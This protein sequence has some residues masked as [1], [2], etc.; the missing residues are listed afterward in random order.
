MF[1]R[2]DEV[3]HR[4]VVA[5]NLRSRATAS[6]WPL[7]YTGPVSV[8]I[9]FQFARPKS[10]NPGPER[11]TYKP[12]LDKLT[13]LVLD[14]LTVSEVIKDDSQVVEIHAYKDWAT[15]DVS[16]IELTAIPPQ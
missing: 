3:F 10:H 14:A 6:E 5:W 16:Y 4:Q 9:F 2:Q 8:D 11:H 7:G 1:K 13:R 15:K 12:D